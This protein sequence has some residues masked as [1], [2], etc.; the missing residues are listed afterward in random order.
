MP[1]CETT[2][3]HRRICKLRGSNQRQKYDHVT[4]SKPIT[5]LQ[6]VLRPASHWTEVN[7]LVELEEVNP[8]LRGGRVENHLGKTTPVHP[9]EIRTSITP[10]SA[11]QLNTTS[12]LANYA[13]EAGIGKVELEEVNPHL[14]GGRVENHLG[15]TTPSSPD[16]D[17]KLD[18]P[19]LSSRAAQHVKRVS[20]LRHRGGKY[21]R[22]SVEGEW[23]TNLE[24][25]ILSTP[26]RDSN[27]NLPI[28]GKFVY[29]ERGALDYATTKAA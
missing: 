17:S 24:E 20:Q 11:V 15:K 8:H 13:T 18:L 7:P 12:A 1:R 5:S 26:Y 2:P 28:V 3:L 27:L 6:L 14:R 21:T 16:R 25:N 4:R 22:I 19:V 9:T 10:S 29:C 23:K